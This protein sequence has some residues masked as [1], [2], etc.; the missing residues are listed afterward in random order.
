MNESLI[1]SRQ[2]ARPCILCG[3]M[4]YDRFSALASLID[5]VE[6]GAGDG[7]P[8]L[9]WTMEFALC[10]AHWPA[11]IRQL[12]TRLMDSPKTREAVTIWKREARAAAVDPARAVAT[13]GIPAGGRSS[14]GQAMRQIACN[15]AGIS[16][17]SS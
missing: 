17:V 13:P 14:A 10:A 11:E 9:D 8:E 1:F 4:T 12:R 5:A 7:G 16:E 2:P 3:V 15:E 6:L